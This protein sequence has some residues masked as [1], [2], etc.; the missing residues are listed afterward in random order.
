MEDD[1]LSFKSSERHSN[2]ESTLQMNAALSKKHVTIH[3]TSEGRLYYQNHETKTS[4]W[5][6]PLD[7]WYSG[8]QGLPY[9]WEVAV[10]KKGKPYY[11]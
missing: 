8:D 7:C 11:I 5:L 6:P 10:D 4:S 2:L 1:R 9:G 3:S